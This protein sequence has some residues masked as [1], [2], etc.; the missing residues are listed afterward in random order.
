MTFNHFKM[1]NACSNIVPTQDEV[2][3]LD[4]PD[5]QDA[6]TPEPSTTA[7]L[8]NKVQTRNSTSGFENFSTS[9]PGH[10]LRKS[11][12]VSGTSSP[13]PPKGERK[14]IHLK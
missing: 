2:D 8:P 11:L 9:P 13:S 5:I 14:L 4:L 7:V 6:H 3:A 12:R 10:L 1:Q